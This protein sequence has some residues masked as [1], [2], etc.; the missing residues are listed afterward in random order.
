MAAVRRKDKVPIFV[1]SKSHEDILDGARGCLVGLHEANF[2]HG[3]GAALFP[4][5]WTDLVV[6]VVVDDVPGV[7]Y[8]VAGGHD[9]WG[10]LP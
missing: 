6:A 8:E 10:G 4:V 9:G 5:D 1:H 3:F 7:G 2:I